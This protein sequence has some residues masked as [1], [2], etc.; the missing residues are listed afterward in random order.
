MPNFHPIKCCALDAVTRQKKKT[1]NQWRC[2]PWY[3]SQNRPL[4]RKARSL[5]KDLLLQ[6][7]KAPSRPE[8]KS[9]S[10]EK[11]NLF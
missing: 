3:N 10:L 2:A 9:V 11:Y 5:E 1:A 6:N 4:K 8:I 7:E